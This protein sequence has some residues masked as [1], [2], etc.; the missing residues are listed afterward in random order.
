MRD[1][2]FLAFVN[3]DSTESRDLKIIRQLAN[4][5]AA[6]PL[7]GWRFV[8]RRKGTETRK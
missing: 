8:S 1:S 7:S 4:P 3:S 2:L 6:R 5:S